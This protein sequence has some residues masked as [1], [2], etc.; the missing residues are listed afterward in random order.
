M[1]VTVEG[2][3]EKRLDGRMFRASGG[4]GSIYVSQGIAYKICDLNKTIPQAKIAELSV[5]TD[6]RIIKPERM[7]FN[8]HGQPT[9]Y[10]MKAVSAPWTPCHLFSRGFM[11]DNRLSHGHIAGFVRQLREITQHCH[12]KGVLLVDLNELNFLMNKAG[13]LF[14]IDVNS[15][16]TKSFPATAIMDSVRDRHTMPFSEGSDWFSWAVV[17]FSMWIGMHPYKGNHPNFKGTVVER[18]DARMKSNV[19]VFHDQARPLAACD[20]LD[21]IP[22]GLAEWYRATFETNAREKPP[23]KFDQVAVARPKTTVVVKSGEIRLEEFMVCADDIQRVFSCGDKLAVLL[24]SG[25]IHTN[26]RNI[27]LSAPHDHLHYDNVRGWMAVSETDP[28]ELRRFGELFGRDVGHFETMFVA[29]CGGLYGIVNGK[30]MLVGPIGDTHVANVLDVPA[31]VFQDDGF[32]MQNLLGRWHV[33]FQRSARECIVRSIPELDGFRPV[34]GC[35]SKTL[36]CLSGEMNG[37]IVRFEIQFGN[38]GNYD[39]R[40]YKDVSGTDF[41]FAVNDAGVCVLID[42]DDAVHAFRTGIGSK[43]RTLIANPGIDGSYRLWAFGEKIL[44]SKG[45]ILYRVSKG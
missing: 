24:T 43:N 2:I 42:A 8:E 18:M 25:K 12:E 10:T 29:A 23:E 4:E 19:S 14:A 44:A 45:K 28:P 11:A 15:Y 17:T 3:G 6:D 35:M 27:S 20:P 26:D 32:L 33:L 5:L 22:K 9:G 36:L 16:Q 34:K 38:D 41:T 40:E 39:L 1:R 21:V 31:A 30:L 7:L 37:T 13:E